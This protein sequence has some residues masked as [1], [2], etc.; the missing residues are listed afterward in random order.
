MIAEGELGQVEF[1][2]ERANN[3]LS[4]IFAGFWFQSGVTVRLRIDGAVLHLFVGS[5]ETSYASIAERSDG[6]RQFVAL[7]AF[8]TLEQ[9]GQAPPVLL[10]DEAEVHLHYDAQA[11]LVQMLARQEVASKI[12]YTTH[13]AGCLPEDLGTGV[14]L[15]EPDSPTISTIRNAFWEDERPGFTPLLYGMGA[16][17][18]AFVSLRYALAVEGMADV[19][20]LPTLLR[21]ATDLSHLGFQVVPGLSRSNEH[22][23]GL[24]E[25]GAPRTAYLVDADSG[26]N[27]I[28]RKLRRAGVPDNRIFRLL[29]GESQNVVVEDLVD[30]KVYVDAVNRE[31]YRSHGDSMSFPSDELTD[32]GRPEVVKAWCESRGIGAPNKRAVAYHIVE[33]RSSSSVASEDYHDSLQQLH[34]EIVAVLQEANS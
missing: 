21:E 12:I 29:N 9:A 2:I 31:L 32:V 14:R 30:P 10:I 11:D 17:T 34:T 15:V 26:G 8:T 5:T 4:T 20:L 3:R 22:G 27:E 19:I 25:R 23:I 13:S 16:S 7:L 1:L 18:L 6:L 24:L 28:R 33:T